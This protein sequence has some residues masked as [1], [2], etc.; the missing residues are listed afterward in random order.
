M[1]IAILAFFSRISDPRFGGT[2][3]TLLNTL[4]NL[5]TI[6]CNILVLGVVDFL[7]LK[8]CSIDSQN[9][10]STQHLQNVRH[11][12][13]TRVP[14]TIFLVNR[15]GQNAKHNYFINTYTH[16]DIC[17][18]LLLCSSWFVL[19]FRFVNQKEVIVRWQ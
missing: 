2:Y 17:L 15:F 11:T 19:F 18:I 12:K 5:G 14:T 6:W 4:S 16:S 8:E 3:M 1:F 7:T 10:C 9:F 13:T